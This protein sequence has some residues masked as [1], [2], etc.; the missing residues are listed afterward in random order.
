ME[1]YFFSK[2][3]SKPKLRK[4]L[5]NPARPYP[6]PKNGGLPRE[7]S[8]TEPSV[9]PRLRS[10]LE[11]NR[12]FLIPEFK[13][14]LAN[15]GLPREWCATNPSLIPRLRTPLEANRHFCKVRRQLTESKKARLRTPLE[16]NRKFLLH[17]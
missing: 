2:L 7:V 12:H 4:F 11:A 10:T 3:A 13:Q 16:A 9:M 5:P 6:N 17:S 14:T 15:R 1:V 8:A